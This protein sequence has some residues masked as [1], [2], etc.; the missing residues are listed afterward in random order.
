MKC[1][2]VDKGWGG[3]GKVDNIGY[4][5]TLLEGHICFGPN[6]LSGGGSVINRGYP[7]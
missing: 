1:W 5:I 6:F 3:S 2:N 4:F 7:V